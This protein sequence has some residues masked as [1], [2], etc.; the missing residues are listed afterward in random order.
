MGQAF[1]CDICKEL[2]AGPPN[3]KI[4]LS[5]DSTNNNKKVISY[6]VKTYETCTKCF[7]K[8]NGVLKWNDYAAS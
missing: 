3:Y 2:R 8:V 1:Q 5:G 7:A 6:G 4:S